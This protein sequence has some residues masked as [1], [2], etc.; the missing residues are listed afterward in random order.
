MS[1]ISLTATTID[2]RS[3]ADIEV[4]RVAMRAAAG[5]SPYYGMLMLRYYFADVVF[6]PLRFDY[7]GHGFAAAIFIARC[8]SPLFILLYTRHACL[9]ARRAPIIIR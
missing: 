6:A 9:L 8:L 7:L 1:A 5:A 3:F 4:E 2:F